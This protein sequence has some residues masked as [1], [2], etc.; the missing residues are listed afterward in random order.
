M[1]TDVDV[2]V[3]GAGPTGL[4]TA[5][6]LAQWGVRVRVVDAAEHPF[7]GSRGKGLQPRSLE[8]LEGLGVTG[9]LVSAGRS[10]MP[11]RHYAEDGTY[12]D[13]DLS[14]GEAPSPDSPYARTLLIP[15]WRVEE[16]LRNRLAELGVAVDWSTG[17]VGFEQGPDRV[18]A[19]LVDGSRVSA[20]YLIGCDGGSSTVR[21]LLGVTFLGETNEAVRMLIADVQLDGVDRDH[22]H[23]WQ[24]VLPRGVALCPLPGTDTFQLQAPDNGSDASLETC[25]AIVDDVVGGGVRLRKATWLS[26]W[27]MNV[28]MVDRYRVG[29]VFLAGDAAHVHSPAG[30]QGMNTGIQD[31]ANLSWKLAHVLAGADEGLLD[32]YEAERLPVA[33]A[34]LGLSTRLTSAPPGLRGEEGRG[35]NQLGISYRGGPLAPDSGAVSGPVAGDRAPDAPCRDGRGRRVRLFE[36]LHGPRWTVLAFGADPAGLPDHVRIVRIGGEHGLADVDGHAARAYAATE[37]DLVLIRPDGYLATRTRASID[38]TTYLSP[39]TSTPVPS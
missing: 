15:Q 20:R 34:V 23:I 6:F 16:T 33:A 28:R 8:I 1:T 39:L 26:K 36:L 35:T 13:T 22:W 10:R 9:R 17:L 24:N 4:A 37:G 27:R 2:L 5:G 12:F 7:V 3:V 11:I 14:A 32:T 31:A 18:T 29:R 25:Q 21:R 19:T 38:I 30:G